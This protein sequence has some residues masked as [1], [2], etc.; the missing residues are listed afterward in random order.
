METRKS[1]VPHSPRRTEVAVDS[2]K[3]ESDSP[4]KR[5]FAFSPRRPQSTVGTNTVGIFLKELD[6]IQDQQINFA[7][8][9]DKERQK[10]EA[11]NNQI[12]VFPFSHPDLA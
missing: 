5:D 9:T 12:Y 4:M 10:Q 7:K 2:R 1:V 11:L 3:L 6:K 8:K